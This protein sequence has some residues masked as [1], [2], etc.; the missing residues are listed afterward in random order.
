MKKNL[1]FKVLMFVS[2]LAIGSFAHDG[3]KSSGEMVKKSGNK[4]SSMSC[5]AG[6]CGGGKMDKSGSCGAGK[7]GSDMKK[8]SMEKEEGG[9]KKKSGNK[10]S[11]MSCG[12]GKCAA[13]K[14]GGAK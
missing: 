9:M 12:A 14:C 4:A 1:L 7:C 3:M 10:P 13:G 5:G 2:L 6:N 8:P 11:K